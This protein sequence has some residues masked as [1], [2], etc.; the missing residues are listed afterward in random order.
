MKK[1]FFLIFSLIFVF[2]QSLPV[3]ATE[4]SQSVVK[5]SLGEAIT[6]CEFS[7]I[8]QMNND[9]EIGPRK[10]I[11]GDGGVCT[12]DYMSGGYILWR[13]T[14][15]TTENHTFNGTMEIRDSNGSYIDS[16]SCFTAALVF[17]QV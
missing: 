5:E 11:M 13:V 4:I 1:I 17:N 16:D 3:F 7:M 8:L 6:H 15:N 10:T 14:P 2:S 9:N 12:L